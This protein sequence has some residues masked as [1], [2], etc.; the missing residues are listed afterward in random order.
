MADRAAEAVFDGEG[1]TR[2]FARLI[3]HF[4]ASWERRKHEAAAR[5]P[6]GGRIRRFPDRGSG[7]EDIAATAGELV[8]WA[9]RA[10][11]DK[12]SL[13]AHLCARKS[14]ASCL[15]ERI[16]KGAATAGA[17]SVGAYAAEIDNALKAANDG[18]RKTIEIQG[19]NISRIPNLNGFIFERHHV[20]T[21]NL[22]AAQKGSPLRA[23]ALES[24]GKNSVDIVI[25]HGR[26]IVKQ[27]QAKFWQDA[28][29]ARKS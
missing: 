23:E 6:A 12:E 9:E 25:R 16:E 3:A 28:E 22:D 20:K 17:S 8:A 19:G 24:Q 7:E 2:E 29:A 13:Q 4:H 15:A 14:K 1:N 21:F 11:A 18:W 26:R 5:R 10:N 27:F